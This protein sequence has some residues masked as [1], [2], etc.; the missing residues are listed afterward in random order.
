[1]PTIAVHWSKPAP[2]DGADASPI[3]ERPGVY[4]ILVE[5]DTG[6]DRVF[7]GETSDL[8]RAFIAHLAG[9]TSSVNLRARMGMG[10]SYFRYW[11]SDA[12]AERAE[13]AA[14]LDDKYDYECGTDYFDG[15]IALVRVHEE[16]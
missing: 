6:I 2:Y 16:E 10:P 5:D 13:V 7:M 8:R 1:M 4:E 14:A 12:P 9:R 15:E 11:M 3:P